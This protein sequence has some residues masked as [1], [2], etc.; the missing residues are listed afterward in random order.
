VSARED[1]SAVAALNPAGS[2]AVP[3]KGGRIRPRRETTGARVLFLPPLVLLLAGLAGPL[4]ALVA[5]AVHA[6]G[7][8]GV[9]TTPLTDH[10]FLRAAWRTLW[11]SAAVSAGTVVIG[12]A[13]A[14]AMAL[15]ARWL[16]GVL[17]GVLLLTFWISLLV[18]TYGWVITLQPAGAVDWFAGLFGA[19]NPPNI[20]QTVPGLLPPMI[21]ILLPYLVLPVYNAARSIDGAQLRA[22]RSLGASEWMT[23]RSVV[24]PALRSGVAAGAILVFILALGFYVTPAFLGGPSGQLVAVVLGTQF[25][26]LKD[27]GGAAAMGLV[28]LVAVLAV[29]WV[30]DRWLRLGERWG[31]M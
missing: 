9:V 8:P 1:G 12:T 18:R 30:A 4:V 20:Y 10:L 22:A 21:H 24:L 26:Q 11:L 13:Y 29:Y 14:L 7:V 6:K 16:S 27:L 28:L 2:V 3:G 23:L 19:K 5:A 17:S 15:A 25:G 31:R